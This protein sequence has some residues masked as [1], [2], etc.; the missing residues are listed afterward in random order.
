VSGTIESDDGVTIAIE[1]D[2]Q[3]GDDQQLVASFVVYE[4]DKI[5]FTMKMDI[6]TERKELDAFESKKPSPE[7]IIKM[8]ELSSVL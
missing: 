7:Q 5:V 4:K 2:G 8:A 1:I 3:L 6:E